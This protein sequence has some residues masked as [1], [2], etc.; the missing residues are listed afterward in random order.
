MKNIDS[1]CIDVKIQFWSILGPL[2]TMTLLCVMPLSATP[3]SLYLAVLIGLPIC[4][5]W[6][7][8]GLAVATIFIAAII[9][10]Q[11]VSSNENFLWLMG[12]CTALNLSLAITAASHSE[13]ESLLSSTTLPTIA[14]DTTQQD[15][16]SELQDTKNQL[17]A[18]KSNSE[19]IQKD[20]NAANTLLAANQN[21]IIQAELKHKELEEK[22]LEKIQTIKKQEEIHNAHADQSEQVQALEYQLQECHALLQ[23]RLKVIEAVRNESHNLYLR[24]ETEITTLKSALNKALEDLEHQQPNPAK[25]DPALAELTNALY[26]KEQKLFELHQK[27]EHMELECNILRNDLSAE[28]ALCASQKAY[29][30]QANTEHK[31]I[32]QKLQEL[33]DARETLTSE[34]RFLEQAIE[35]SQSTL[36]EVINEKDQKM[37]L[38]KTENESLSTELGA[39]I[40]ERN[41][42]MTNLTDIER[43]WRSSE[44]R[45]KQLQEQFSDKSKLVDDTRKQL[46]LSEENVLRL[47]HIQNE[48]SLERSKNLA[49]LEKH[50][51]KIESEFTSTQKQ[52]EQEIN[53]LYELI[54]SL[55]SKL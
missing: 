19:I 49:E 40:I 53:S 1:F 3:I 7:L 36:S 44:G 29:V 4:L 31:N 30:E 8:R 17:I 13:V 47:Q 42:A 45:Y 6:K 52:Q 5:I 51:S 9:L 35:R 18:E 16:K 34:K 37:G 50:L 23:D 10:Y 12:L 20:L 27:L 22:V 25:P 38:L 54:D 33:T 2:L 46:F 55:N 24:R 15:L 26:L 39:M 14:I 32:H 28:K 41:Q 21:T 11:L 43:A 48:F